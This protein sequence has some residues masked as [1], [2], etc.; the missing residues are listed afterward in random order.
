VDRD[1]GTFGVEHFDY[2]S[3]LFTSSDAGY[4]RQE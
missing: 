1:S 3:L 2:F 4:S